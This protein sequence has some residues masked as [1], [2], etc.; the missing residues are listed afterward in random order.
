MSVDAPSPHVIVTLGAVPVAGVT[1]NVT[2]CPTV[3]LAGAV[4]S[5]TDAVGLTVTSTLPEK[6]PTRAV[7][8][9]AR[10][11]V[12]LTRACPLP[13]V[14]PV[15]ALRVPAV[16]ENVTLTPLKVRLL[17]PVAVATISTEPPLAGTLE[18]LAWTTTPVIAAAP[19]V[20]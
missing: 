12:R 18:G 10:L 13:S 7:T 19:I 20:I 3:G 14:V 11:V 9:V 1:V 8:V 6:E 17:A 4:V 2:G 5:A 15:G 16:A